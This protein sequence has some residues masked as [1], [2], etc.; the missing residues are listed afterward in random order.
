MRN[1]APASAPGP[2]SREAILFQSATAYLSSSA[3]Q[4]VRAGSTPVLTVIPG[5]KRACP[6]STPDG[7]LCLSRVAPLQPGCYEDFLDARTLTESITRSTATEM[8]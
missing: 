2:L 3:P 7:S 4:H 1:P 5:L 6:G 8:K